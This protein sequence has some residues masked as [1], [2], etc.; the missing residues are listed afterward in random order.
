MEKAW[1]ESK[2][3]YFSRSSGCV[4]KLSHDSSSW[5]MYQP[6]LQ[7]A[8]QEW[9]EKLPRWGMTVGGVLYQLRPLEHCTDARDGSYWLT[10]STMDHLP[11][12]EGEALENALYRGK[13][14]KSKRKVS[15]RLNE[16][17]VYPQMFPTP[18][19]RDATRNKGGSPSDCRR[20]T[21][22]LPTAILFA[23][24]TEEN[25]GRLNPEMIGKKL[26]PKWVSVL[27]GFPTTWT[28][29]EPLETQLCPVRHAKLLK[30]FRDCN[31]A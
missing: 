14:R 20:N 9:L 19:V 16:Q 13:E 25:V 17:V 8:D 27:M 2:A 23:I 10:P 21:P 11:V 6:L 29:L 22:N 28:D 12:R 30:Y 3:D 4:A 5:R 1:K 26:C 24:P 15:G 31:K 18:T 7:E